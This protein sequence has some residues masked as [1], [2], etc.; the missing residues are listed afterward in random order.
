MGSCLCRTNENTESVR[1]SE[2][3]ESVSDMEDMKDTDDTEKNE[4]V[5]GCKH[6]RRKCRI[7]APCCNTVYTCRRCHDEDISERYVSSMDPDADN[8]KIDRYKIT[9][10]VCMICE[11]RQPK[12]QYCISCNTCFGAHYCAKCNLWDD[13]DRGLNH[14]DKCGNCRVYGKEGEKYYHCDVCGVCR[15]DGDHI[16]INITEATCPICMESIKEGVSINQLRCGH[17]LHTECLES[18]MET[19]LRCPICLKSM[20]ELPL[21]NLILD[22]EVSLTPMPDELTHIKIKV[23]CNDCHEKSEVNF[24]IVGLKC[25][26]CGSYN[27]RRI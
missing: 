11:K 17:W 26:A 20:C 13:E 2:E 6:Y 10:V 14:C 5:Y 3:T 18:Y 19:S 27:T 7:V 21:T 9:E 23:L 8:H 4:L 12:S 16:C 22:A 24:H 25:S 1:D 15:R